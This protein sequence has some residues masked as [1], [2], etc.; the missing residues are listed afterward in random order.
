MHLLS[1]VVGVSLTKGRDYLQSSVVF[2][3]M[4]KDFIWM[5]KESDGDI[6]SSK[7]Q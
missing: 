1:A 4:L 6:H 2:V 3:L 7:R 5:L